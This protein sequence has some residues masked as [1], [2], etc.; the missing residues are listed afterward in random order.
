MGGGGLVI[1]ILSAR[2][3]KTKTHQTKTK[4]SRQS[5]LWSEETQGVK[6]QPKPWKRGS[7]GCG[8][9]T[10]PV[11]GSGSRQSR[12]RSPRRW[13]PHVARFWLSA[14]S[15]LLADSVLALPAAGS[16]AQCTLVRSPPCA[17]D[18]SLPGAGHVLQLLNPDQAHYSACMVPLL[19]RA[20]WSRDEIVPSEASRNE[21]PTLFLNS[22]FEMTSVQ[23]LHLLFQTSILCFALHFIRLTSVCW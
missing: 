10:S 15:L 16:P 12:S 11:S 13:Q 20:N 14:E 18:L 2:K 4:K 1:K 6:R 21:S 19:F 7:R 3:N 22:D 8:S 9:W 5:H 17:A 23:I